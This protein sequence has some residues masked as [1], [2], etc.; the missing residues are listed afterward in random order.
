MPPP[1]SQ[2]NREAP[3][4]AGRRSTRVL[5]AIPISLSGK[6]SNGR[7]FK[8]NSRTTIINKQGAKVTTYHE[9]ALGAEVVIENRAL[10]RKAKAHVVWLGERRTPKEAVEIGVQLLEAENLWGVDLA[11]GG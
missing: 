3:G 8:E 6:D 9:L 11:P 10:G 1:P 5:V 7:A 2:G 4:A